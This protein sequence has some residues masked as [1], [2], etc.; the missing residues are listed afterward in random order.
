MASKLFVN[1][2]PEKAVALNGGLKTSP[3]NNQSSYQE[4]LSKRERTFYMWPLPIDFTL[5]EFRSNLFYIFVRAFV[6]VLLMML[7]SKKLFQVFKYGMKVF[8]NIEN[9]FECF[10]FI[11]N[12]LSQF[13]IED[14]APAF[15]SLSVLFGWISFA[16]FFQSIGLFKIGSYSLALR[17]TIQNSFKFIPF[18]VFIYFGE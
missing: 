15:G 8:G 10:S 14:T 6:N 1:L 4:I 11:L 5:D 7:M 17:K 16:F 3:N 18:F 2:S 9:W 13:A 12:V